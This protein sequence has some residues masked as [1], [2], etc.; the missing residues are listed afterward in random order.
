MI[1]MLARKEWPPNRPRKNGSMVGV[2]L[3]SRDKR[4]DKKYTLYLSIQKVQMKS[5]SNRPTDSPAVQNHQ[6]TASPSSCN[7]FHLEDPVLLC[8]I[9]FRYGTMP[10]V[11][12]LLVSTFEYLIVG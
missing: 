9:I 11:I 8:L 10:P 5:G 7:G 6:F 1:P 2:V 12:R 3:L 4:R